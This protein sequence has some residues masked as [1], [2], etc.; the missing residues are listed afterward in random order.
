MQIIVAAE[1]IDKVENYN[2]AG[3]VGLGR[4]LDMYFI[5]CGDLNLVQLP[6]GVVVP[7]CG[8]F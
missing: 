5:L 1:G 3:R 7:Y 2:S 6:G 8:L 4:Q